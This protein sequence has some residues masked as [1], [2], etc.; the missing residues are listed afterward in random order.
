MKVSLE[1]SYRSSFMLQG[2]NY[3]IIFPCTLYSLFWWVINSVCENVENII[4]HRSLNVFSFRGGRVMAGI[5]VNL[6]GFRNIIETLPWVCLWGYF[7]ES[8]S[9][10]WIST[11]N[12]STVLWT[13]NN[14]S[15]WTEHLQHDQAS[16]LQYHASAVV[17]ACSL[18]YWASEALQQVKAT[19]LFYWLNIWS[20]MHKRLQ[21]HFSSLLF[22]SALVCCVTTVSFLCYWNPCVSK[23]SHIH[24]FIY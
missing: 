24:H 22:F 9:W 3:V 8:F 2:K 6:T 15:F 10:Q 13:S 14:W 21:S 12:V 17:I 18:I 1:Y 19:L 7:S 20:H 11:M 23:I 4:C 5:V 16:P